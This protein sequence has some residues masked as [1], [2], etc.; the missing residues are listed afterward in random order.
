MARRL[1]RR[2][3]EET[4]MKRIRVYMPLVLALAA[5]PIA[6]FAQSEDHL[7]CFAVKDSAPKTKYQ[8]TITN[9]ARLP[10]LPRA[11]ARED[12]VR[13]DGEDA[14]HADTARRRSDRLCRRLVPVLSREV[15]EAGV[16]R[17]CAR[18]V[19]TARD[20]VPR[21]ALRLRAGEPERAATGIEHDDDAAGQR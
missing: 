7:A 20:H 12:R 14:G 18:P 9:A 6:A 5:A 15:R 21:V 16:E 2:T 11:H 19:R 8:V 13:S 1:L 4:I 17:Q 10:E 3:G